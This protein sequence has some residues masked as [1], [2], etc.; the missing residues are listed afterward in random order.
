MK[1]KMMRCALLGAMAFLTVA[2][3]AD[4]DYKNE[5]D[6]HLI[7]RF[8]PDYEYEWNDFLDTFFDGGKDTIAYA[9]SLSI[10]PVYHFAKVADEDEF[11]GGF[12]LAIGKDADAS[13]ARKPS[14]FAVF[15][16]EGGNQKSRAYAVFHDTTDVL[17]PEHSVRIQIPN[18]FSSCAP[19]NIYVHNVQAAV[20]A[21][22]HGVGLADGP[23]QA[24]DHLTLTVT[25][26]LKNKVGGTKEIKLIDGTSYLKEW[27]K[28]DLS[29]LGSIDALELY[30][31]SSRDD[32][33]LYC[34]QDDMGYHYHEIY[35]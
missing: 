5:Y 23:F 17:M 14:R 28:V 33:P 30:L 8:E 12:A 2:C 18:E 16:A 22:V 26:S 15:D 11:L 35:Q 6:S 29:D 10:G 13:A 21:A 3:F 24:G 27:T 9:P 1:R 25:G 19:E 20:Q 4:G 31:T 32:F 34:C 7:V